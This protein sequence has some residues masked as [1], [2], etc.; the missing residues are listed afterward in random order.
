MVVRAG[1]GGLASTAASTALMEFP[2]PL[3]VDD[4]LDWGADGGCIEDSFAYVKSLSNRA[5]HCIFVPGSTFSLAGS[6]DT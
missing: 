3:V 5:P 4:G 2:V 6:R 1:A